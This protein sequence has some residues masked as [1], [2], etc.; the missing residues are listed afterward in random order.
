[1]IIDIAVDRPGADEYDPA[2]TGYVAHLD[3]SESVVEVLNDQLDGVT[4]RFGGFDESRGDYRYAPGKWSLK[5]VLG[6]L[7]DTERVFA[8]RALRIGRGDATALLAFDDQSYVPEMRA[9]DR[10]LAGVV[11][12]WLAVRGATLAL[13]RGFPEQAWLRRGSASGHPISVRSLAFV[14]AGH[15]RHHLQVVDARYGE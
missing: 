12:E 5:E 10:T 11:E 1:M 2:F 4:R 7:S 14:I 9:E 8:Y 13:F 15:T 3:E 6:H